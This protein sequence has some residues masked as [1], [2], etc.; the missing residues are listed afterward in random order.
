MGDSISIS[1]WFEY[2]GRKTCLLIIILS[3]VNLLHFLFRSVSIFLTSS[4]HTWLTV[5]LTLEYIKIEHLLLFVTM[6]YSMQMVNYIEKY[7]FFL[8]YITLCFSCLLTVTIFAR[9]FI[10]NLM[11]IILISLGTD[12]HFDIVAFMWMNQTGTVLG[13]T[14]EPELGK[15]IPGPPYEN[16]S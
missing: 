3:I 5:F 12:H 6:I 4:L 1:I 8:C 2:G 11:A 10:C 15:Y 9:C 7:S 16:L 13:M 14:M